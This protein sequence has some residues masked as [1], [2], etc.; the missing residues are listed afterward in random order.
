MGMGM[1]MGVGMALGA[2]WIRACCSIR[3]IYRAFLLQQTTQAVL[4]AGPCVSLHGY[5]RLVCLLQR[6][7]Q[8]ARFLSLLKRNQLDEERF[9]LHHK[10]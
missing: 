2:A 1:G 4:R 3:C 5:A 9:R 7:S 8:A 10:L 6:R